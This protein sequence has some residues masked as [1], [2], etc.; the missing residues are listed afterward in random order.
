MKTRCLSIFLLTL[1]VAAS[2][3][4]ADQPISVQFVPVQSAEL[5]FEMSLTG[6]FAA[7]DAVDL[8]FRQGGRVTEVLV[9]EGDR[10]R[11][12]QALAYTDPVQQDQALSVAEASLSSARATEAQA[13]QA[14]DRAEAMLER[15]VGTRAGRDQAQQALSQAEG[16]VRRARSQ[17]DQARRAVE[18][19]VLRAPQDSVVTARDVDAGQIVGAA[20]AV[21][22]LAVLGGLE[23]VFQTPDVPKLDRAMGAEVVLEPIDVDAPD[24]I[25]RVIEIAPLVDPQTGTVT[26]RVRVQETGQDAEMDI[27][28]LGAAVRGTVH[29]PAGAA[30]AVP[31]TALTRDGD[32]PAV[33][34]VN[35]EGRADLTQV[36]IER[37]A[38][39]EVLL[40]GGV[41]EGQVVVGAGSQM[42][43]PGRPVLDAGI[44]PETVMPAATMAPEA[45]E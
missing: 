25:G 11:A 33:W 35:A 21:I 1:G 37:F 32:Q 6:T 22:S 5:T 9:D 39:G 45:E 10:V 23:A 12:G 15:G 31:W 7:K 16:A 44:A 13:R 26:L 8:G 4:R 34:V 2:V 17:A 18:D 27:G 41:A 38:N 14:F 28:L 24:L 19:T 36:Q 43:Y 29:F 42:L 20:Q 30:I 40:K 3:A